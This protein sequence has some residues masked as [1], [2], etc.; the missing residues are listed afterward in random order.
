[1]FIIGLCNLSDGGIEADV[2]SF[3]DYNHK[4]VDPIRYLGGMIYRVFLKF[5]LR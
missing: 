2:H 4:M 3:N 5:F 1:M